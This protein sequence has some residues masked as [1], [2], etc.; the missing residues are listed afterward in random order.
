MM[1]HMKLWPYPHL[2]MNLLKL[3]TDTQVY[4][5]TLTGLILKIDPS[6]RGGISSGFGWTGSLC[7]QPTNGHAHVFSSW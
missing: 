5:I 7:T 1:A 6:M 3:F 4:L 2:S